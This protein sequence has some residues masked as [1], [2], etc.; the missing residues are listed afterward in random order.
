MR[1]AFQ[2]N[3]SINHLG[4]EKFDDYYEVICDHDDCE[5][6]EEFTVNDSYKGWQKVVVMEDGITQE[7]RHLCPVHHLV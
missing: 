1:K 4:R 5:N 7:T 6:T 3:V 2:L